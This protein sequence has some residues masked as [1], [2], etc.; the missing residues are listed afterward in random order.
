MYLLNVISKKTILKE[1]CEPCNG[2][3][4]P[5]TSF[6]T[7]S[8]LFNAKPEQSNQSWLDVNESIIKKPKSDDTGILR[9]MLFSPR[10]PKVEKLDKLGDVK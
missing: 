9:I 8:I 7:N 4:F 6:N 5:F 1:T 10:A 3:T 2:I